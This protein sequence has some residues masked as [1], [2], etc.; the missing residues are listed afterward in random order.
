[1]RPLGFPRRWKNATSISIAFSFYWL[2]DQKWKYH[3]RGTQNGKMF[4]K[5]LHAEWVTSPQSWVVIT[6]SKN[7]IT[8]KNLINE[9][10]TALLTSKACNSPYIQDHFK[11]FFVLCS[12]EMIFSQNCHTM[13][14][15]ELICMRV[16]VFS[17]YNPVLL[18]F[19]A[20]FYSNS[21]QIYHCKNHLISL[22]FYHSIKFQLRNLCKGWKITCISR[23][24]AL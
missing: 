20:Q 8:V 15:K 22:Y 21:I 3:F 9:F 18:Q 1:M 5:I 13:R 23:R 4:K 2:S 24:N 11:Q 6:Q 19:Y 17:N 7:H 10:L 16:C 12:S 14:T